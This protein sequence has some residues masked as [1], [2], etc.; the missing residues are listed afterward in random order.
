VVKTTT[1]YRDSH[2]LYDYEQKSS[3]VKDSFSLNSPVKFVR[4]E[5]S[6]VLAV[7]EYSEK[8][9]AKRLAALNYADG[10]D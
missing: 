4:S 1:W 3:Q 10:G 5:A 8:P 7:S 2:G 6:Q 9:D